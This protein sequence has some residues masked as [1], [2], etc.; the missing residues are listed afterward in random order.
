MIFPW[1]IEGITSSVFWLLEVAVFTPGWHF[2]IPGPSKSHSVCLW[3]L[4]GSVYPL[5]KEV[6]QVSLFIHCTPGLGNS[7]SIYFL[8]IYL[9]WLCPVAWDLSSLTWD[10][11]WDL[12]SEAGVLTTGPPGKPFLSL[13]LLSSSFPLLCLLSLFEILQLEDKYAK[14]IFQFSFL[15]L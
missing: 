3:A 1:T 2:F 6:P 13:S 5:C 15:C 8:F 12:G 14:F 4:N 10:Q 7:L 11:T 9:S